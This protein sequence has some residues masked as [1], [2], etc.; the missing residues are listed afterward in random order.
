MD[1][2]IHLSH[3]SPKRYFLKIRARIGCHRA[4]CET[5]DPVLVV[6]LHNLFSHKVQ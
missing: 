6:L 2:T 5:D 4:V 3:I 1:T